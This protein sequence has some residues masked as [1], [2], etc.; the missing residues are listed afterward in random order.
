MKILE[1]QTGAAGPQS[2]QVHARDGEGE[3]E[4]A[5]ARLPEI[6]A[7]AGRDGQDLA[8]E[9]VGRELGEAS[10]KLRILAGRNLGGPLSRT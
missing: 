1:R 9:A 5:L 4:L 10:G 8:L 2:L 7:E 3:L 6:E